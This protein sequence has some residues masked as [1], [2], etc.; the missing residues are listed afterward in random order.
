[1]YSAFY[2]PFT[3]PRVS[4][5]GLAGSLKE[6]GVNWVYVVGLA[7]DYCVKASAVDARKEGMEVVLILEGTRAV[8]QEEESIK[9]VVEEL[10]GESVR[11]IQGL[12]AEELEWLK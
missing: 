6:D 9:R 3:S 12:E 1:M 4:D 8:D 10:R 7:F 2:D 5:S 11:V